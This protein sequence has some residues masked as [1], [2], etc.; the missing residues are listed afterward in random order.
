MD[1]RGYGRAGEATRTQRWTTGILLLSGLCGLGVGT[2]ALLD[3][4]APRWLAVPMLVVGTVVAVVGLVSAGRRVQRSRY[5][6]D[7]WQLAEL[8]VA[9][10]GLAVG[11]AIWW[12]G[13][14]ETLVIYPSLTEMPY[15]SVLAPAGVLIGLV[16][17]IA[18]PPPRLPVSTPP[19]VG[20]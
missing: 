16:P 13:R 12:L 14:T 6:P 7:R 1:A 3:R 11:A 4:T 5:R 10:S 2:Y 19:E 15:L 9:G 17:A 20:A 8:V 18:A